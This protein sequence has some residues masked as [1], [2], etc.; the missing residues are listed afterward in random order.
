MRRTGATSLDKKGNQMPRMNKSSVVKVIINLIP[1]LILQ[2]CSQQ[3]INVVKDG[4]FSFDKTTTIGKALDSSDLFYKTEWKSFENSNHRNIVEFYG[5]L[6]MEKLL[7]SKEL[8]DEY[9]KQFKSKGKD[10]F[11]KLEFVVYANNRD[12]ELLSSAL[13]TFKGHPDFTD[14]KTLIKHIYTNDNMLSIYFRDQFQKKIEYDTKTKEKSEAIRTLLECA[15]LNDFSLAGIYVGSHTGE[16][17]QSLVKSIL[18]IH[19]SSI[20]DPTDI[21]VY[22]IEGEHYSF[23]K[24]KLLTPKNA[25]ECSDS[26]QVSP[27]S[28][29]TL[30]KT[31]DTSADKSKK[32]E[33][34][35]AVNVFINFDKKCSINVAITSFI[36]K[37]NVKYTKLENNESE[38][39]SAILQ[40]IEQIQS[41]IAAKK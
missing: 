7:I 37:Y 12:F 9:E 41:G 36:G 25:T 11:I 32:K 38:N 35:T 16:S 40:Q 18:I 23:G 31:N 6:D 24:G 19:D 22:E 10:F 17:N 2:A 28:L 39:V 30:D 8:Y 14:R 1:L 4:V 13:N 3:N 20:F 34:K 21:E 27:Y 33:N 15:K 26:F 5:Y 29:V